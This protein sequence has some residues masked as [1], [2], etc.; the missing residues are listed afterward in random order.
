MSDFLDGNGNEIPDITDE[1]CL[2]RAR[3]IYPIEIGAMRTSYQGAVFKHIDAGDPH[4]ST[5]AN[6]ILK[7]YLETYG[8]QS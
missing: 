3:E 6:A 2:R 4:T 5:A 7:A 1:E 8:A